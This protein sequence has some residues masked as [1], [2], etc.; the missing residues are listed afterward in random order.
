LVGFAESQEACHNA[1]I[2][3][4]GQT[5]T[6]RFLRV[7]SPKADQP[8]PARPSHPGRYCVRTATLVAP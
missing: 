8:P 4:V 5:G 2:G 7:A 3:Y 1:E 6:V